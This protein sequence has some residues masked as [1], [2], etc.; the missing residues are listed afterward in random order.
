MEV[1]KQQTIYFVV[2]LVL[3][4]CIEN[5]RM[6]GFVHDFI[7]L[8]IDGPV[9]CWVNGSE[10]FI[11]LDSEHPSIL[12]Q[13]VVPGGLDDLDF[14]IDVLYEPKGVVVWVAHGYHNF[15]T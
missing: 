14:R 13:G 8:N 2:V 15:I 10:R 5:I 1:V 6:I 11:C 9:G 3:C 4:H 7:T 12:A